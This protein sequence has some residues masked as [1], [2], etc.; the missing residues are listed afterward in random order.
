MSGGSGGLGRWPGG[1]EWW[2]E[3]E[4]RKQRK[5]DEVKEEGVQGAEGEVLW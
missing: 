3:Q 5:V 2:I 1:R 4:G